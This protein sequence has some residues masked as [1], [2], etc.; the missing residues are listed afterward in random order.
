MPPA[1]R[2][3]TLG[4]VTVPA[5]VVTVGAGTSTRGRGSGGGDAG[6]VPAG[7][8]AVGRSMTALLRR[9]SPVIWAGGKRRCRRR[10]APRRGA[11]RVDRLGPGD[12]PGV[13]AAIQA[14]AL[15][16]GGAPLLEAQPLA[17]DGQRARA[18]VGHEL[19]EA[20]GRAEVRARRVGH[21]GAGV[22]GEVDGAGERPGDQDESD[23]A[24]PDREAHAPLVQ[25]DLDD[26]RADDFDQVVLELFGGHAEGSPSRRPPSC[27]RSRSSFA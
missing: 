24:E 20:A 10:P 6:V 19:A 15:A 22:D 5:G 8:V 26:E 3:H 25:R 12:G 27:A 7:V 18:R 2:A 16:R 9:L 1:G 14:P 21:G 4:T 23:D 11:R 17:E 13:V